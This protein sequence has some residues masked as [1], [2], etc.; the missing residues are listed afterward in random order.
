MASRCAQGVRCEGRNHPLNI[1]P[2]PGRRL[3]RDDRG[4]VPRLYRDD[5]GDCGTTKCNSH[6]GLRG[7]YRDVPRSPPFT[8]ACGRARAHAGE[9]LYA[10]GCVAVHRGTRGTEPAPPLPGPVG[11]RSRRV[12]P[13]RVVGGGV[14]ND[15]S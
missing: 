1:R 12:G 2:R 3:Y 7:L 14:A 13:R 4:F 11:P 5:L 9:K 15:P 6:S 10:M 8:H